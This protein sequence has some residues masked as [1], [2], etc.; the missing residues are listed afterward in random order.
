MYSINFFTFTKVILDQVQLQTENVAVQMTE[1]AQGLE[2]QDGT[3]LMT[4]EKAQGSIPVQLQFQGL[5]PPTRS[6][7]PR[8]LIRY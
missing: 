6:L 4:T 3:Q 7:D 8:I 2:P 5:I 1:L